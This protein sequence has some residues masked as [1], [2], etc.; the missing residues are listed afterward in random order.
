MS[1]L[2]GSLVKRHQNAVNLDALAGY[3]G[4]GNVSS[5]GTTVSVETALRVATVLACVRFKINGLAMVPL[6]VMRH[7]MKGDLEY[8]LPAKD[9]GLYDLLARKPNSWQTSFE[10]R[11]MV[12]LHR[13]LTGNAYVFK[14]KVGGKIRELVPLDSKR[15]TPRRDENY[16]DVY[17]VRGETG[18][19]KV[20][21]AESIWHLRGPSWDGFV[22]MDTIKLAAEAIGLSIA[23]ESSQANLHKNGVQ[24]SGMYSVEA[25]LEED[26]YKALRKWIEINNAGLKNSSRVMLLDRGAKWQPFNMSGVDS[27]HLETRNHQRE[28]VCLAMGVYPQVL[29]IGDKAPTFASAEQ[30]FGASVVHTLGPEYMAWEQSINCHLLTDKE[31]KD[32][33]YAKFFSNGLLRGAT[34]DRGEFYRMMYNTGSINPNEIRGLEDLNP[35]PGGDAYRVPLNME[36]PANSDQ[37]DSLNPAF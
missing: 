9:L 16:N 22:G 4:G 36:D 21:P 11:Q 19:N 23:A 32:G 26:Q 7:S 6:K 33:H 35:Y 24:P 14:N 27:Q 20:F 17:E 10:F 1:I 15:V 28:E 5:S 30:F 31:V 37:T 18:E 13:V 2:F 3:L 34:K 12:E 8:R 25:T 29:G